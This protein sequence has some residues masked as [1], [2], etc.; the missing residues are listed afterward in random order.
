[1]ELHVLSQKVEVDCPLGIGGENEFDARSHAASRGG[2][3]QRQ[4]HELNEPRPDKVAEDV[5]FVPSPP[6]PPP[7]SPY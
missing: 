2:E 5:P 6:G 3:Y 4:R 7:V 1:M